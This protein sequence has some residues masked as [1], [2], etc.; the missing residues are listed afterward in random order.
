MDLHQ[1]NETPAWEWPDDADKFL[2]KALQD[3]SL[4]ADDRLLAVEL[5]GEYSVVNDELA[6]ALLG[7]AQ[8]RDMEDAVRGRAAI[9]LGPALEHAD[10]LGF[11]DPDDL[12]ISQ[13]VF[14]RLKSGLHALYHDPDSSKLVRRK[15]LEASVRAPQDW[16]SQAIR[17]AYEDQD[18]DWT[19]TAVFCMRFI[20]GF[21][22][23]IFQSLQ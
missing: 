23:E 21:D 14:E 3:K 13:P 1:L 17:S 20:S 6:D 19:L 7:V 4:D 11:G 10:T 22:R 18:A 12:L 8:N 5:A 2:L 16:H 9:S 15:V